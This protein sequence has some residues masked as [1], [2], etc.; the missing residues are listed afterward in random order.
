MINY[1]KKFGVW[2]YILF[3]SGLLVISKLTYNF[4]T[5]TL[6]GTAVNLV[7]FVASVLMMSAPS[8]LVRKVK[9]QATKWTKK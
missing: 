7:A 6:E 5:D 4:L 8:F 2:E 9:E 3:L 1:V